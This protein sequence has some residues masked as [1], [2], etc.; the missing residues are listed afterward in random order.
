MAVR[1][2]LHTERFTLRTWMIMSEELPRN[3]EDF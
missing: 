2:W 1:F 3:Y